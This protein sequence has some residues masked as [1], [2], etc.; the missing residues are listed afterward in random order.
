MKNQYK[1]SL[2]FP[3]PSSKDWK[4]GLTKKEINKIIKDSDPLNKFK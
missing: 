3:L 1:F 2:I 4:N